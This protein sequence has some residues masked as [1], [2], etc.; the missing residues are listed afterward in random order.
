MQ[1]RWSLTSCC[2]AWDECISSELATSIYGSTHRAAISLSVGIR[3]LLE[4]D[5][6]FAVAAEMSLLAEAGCADAG[7]EVVEEA[8]IGKRCR[9]E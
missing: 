2:K 5:V 4:V 1:S 9:M 8:M 3:L 6:L 7:G